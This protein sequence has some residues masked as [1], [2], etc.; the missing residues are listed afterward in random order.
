MRP[1]TSAVSS[2]KE[3]KSKRQTPL[4]KFI[5]TVAKILLIFF[6]ALS[7][8]VVGVVGGAVFGLIKTAAPITDEMLEISTLT[9]F[10]YDSDNKQIAQLKGSE[11]KNRVRVYDKDIPKYLKD[12]YVAI[13]D[14]RF[15]D[16][17]G[18]DIIR[19]ASAAISFITTA[20][21][22]KHGG[23]TITQQVVKNITGNVKR[24][25]PRKVQ[26]QWNAIQLE[27]R[28]EKWQI[29]EIYMNIIY[30]G[31][32]CH[33]VQAA[34]KTYFNKNVSDLSL[35]E[36]AFLA[37]ITNSPGRYDPFTTKGRENAFKRQRIILDKML[38][39]GKISQE[40]YDQAL[41]EELVFNDSTATNSITRPQSKQS[42]F[43][44]QVIVDV[45]KDLS[46]KYGWS[47]DRAL[48]SVYNTGY[49]I[50]TTQ[51]STI[52]KAMDEV[53]TDDKYFPEIKGRKEHSQA[54]M[55]ILDPYTG[56][57]KALY[58]GYGVKNSDMVFNRASSTLMKRQAGSSF[59][60][61]AVYAPAVDTGIITPGS[62]FDDIPVHLNEQDKESRYPTNYDSDGYKGLTNIR[63]AIRKS[64]NV[65]AAQ[66]W[67][68][69]PDLSLQYIKKAGIN[70]DK[71]RF[72]SIAL[73]GLEEGI[74]P[75]QMAASY[76]PFVDKGR[77]HEPTTYT[78]VLDK[79]GKTILEKKP[80]TTVVYKD[81]R[82]AFIMTN[83][84]EDVVKKGGT[85]HPYGVIQNKKKELIPTAGKT[86]TTSNFIDKWFV[87]Y[88]PYYV[89]A[90]WFGYDN[91][92]RTPIRL[93]R[94]EYN[95]ALK[96][97]NAVML[98]AH[99]NLSYKAFDEP[100]GI[101]RKPICI[102]SGK[103]PTD[104]CAKDPRGNSVREEVFMKGTEPKD[105]DTCNVHVVG[106]VC[107]QSKD[108]R[109][110]NLL[111]G[112]YCPE[113]SLIEKVFI[114]RKEPFM[115]QYPDDPYPEDH[116]YELPAG[117]YCNVHGSH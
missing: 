71:E 115:P 22:P 113:A 5:F 12:A 75:L 48:L 55:V 45:A 91:K 60:P 39:L 54:A 4:K 101:V 108:H 103:T 66:I 1:K 21:N 30:M 95:Q 94:E 10:V 24:S 47:Y 67:L 37:G 35:A 61:I 99:E 51:D 15:Y 116:K 72:L 81:D 89:G 58:G 46:A 16:H 92:G 9:T 42:Y 84:M 69:N 112:S 6:I 44:D 88:S 13:E 17:P 52:Q 27:S 97:W 90:T 59:K 107:S 14:E 26:E 23:S 79:N 87:G 36:C 33:G 93:H 2:G 109:G 57:V 78:K 43:V 34:S 62:I 29:L 85:A 68:I 28:Y 63:D 100:A 77:Y 38:E 104:L 65:V 41:K 19:I 3:K 70:R 86:G 31:N 76:Q 80:K 117:E 105:F 50:Y 114:Q 106:R 73:G 102:Y 11:N 83:M 8:A 98:K 64:V 110:R 49:T 96:I 111:F 74:N 56:H 53:F 25:L 7:C 32:G 18:I 82:T 40:E 20:G